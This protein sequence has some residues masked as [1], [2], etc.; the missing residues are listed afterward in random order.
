M[1]LRSSRVFD[2]QSPSIGDMIAVRDDLKSSAQRV[3]VNRALS[4][5]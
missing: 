3:H 2:A 5:A 4:A 1:R